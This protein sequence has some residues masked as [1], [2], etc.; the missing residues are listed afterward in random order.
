MNPEIIAIKSALGLL[1]LWFFLAYLWRDYRI[2]AFRDHVFS[3]RD[4]LFMFAASG[5]IGFEDPA[6]TILRYRMNV[7]LRYAHEFTLFR[8]FAI[9]VMNPLPVKNL[10]RARWEEAVNN[11]ESEYAR[12]QLH[13]F[14]TI[15]VIAILQLMVYR[16]FFLYVLLRPIMEIVRTRDVFRDVLI[17]APRVESKVEQLESEAL[18]EDAQRQCVDMAAA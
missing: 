5:G 14:N 10:D 4:R 2:D 11:V 16:S 18:D 15:L 9:S 6:Y 1:F 17:K 13:N 3:I 7:V 8:V 12:N